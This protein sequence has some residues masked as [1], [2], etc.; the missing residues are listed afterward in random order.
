MVR[1]VLGRM[2]RRFRRLCALSAVTLLALPAVHAT[3]RVRLD[4]GHLQ[5]EIAPGLGGRI[6]HLSLPG[7][8][9]LL[10]V[11]DAVANIPPPVPSAD[12]E[13]IPYMGHELWT[14][15]Q[16]RWWL[17]QDV[18]AERRAAAAVWPP[19]PFL[20]YGRNR[21]VERSPLALVLEGV[22]S[23]V[24]G[25]RASQSFRL[26]G[27]TPATLALG[28]EAVN[29]RE[30]EVR[31]NLWFNTRLPAGSRVFVPV[32]READARL[33]ADEDASFAGPVAWW[34]DGLYSLQLAPPPPGKDGRRGKIFI[35]PSAGW[36]AGFNAGQ[37]L[38]IRFERQPDTA[39]DPEHGQVE[40]YQQWHAD[41]PDAGLLELEVHAPMRS[42]APGETMRSG[43]TWTVFP[44]DGPD[45]LEAQRDALVAALRALGLG[46]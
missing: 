42:L 28:A 3:E 35:A 37:L 24:S 34:R 21:I 2:M 23:P 43:E 13:N 1:I 11:G 4:D 31:R 6:V 9:N 39:I 45:T 10:K 44:Y 18:N 20:A 27:Q 41:D 5:V 17:D 8:S 25:L 30:R 15:A 7:R 12:G 29:I 14:G 26:S 38:L 36:I 19:D 22:D 46:H 16:S 33:R 32:A 40:L